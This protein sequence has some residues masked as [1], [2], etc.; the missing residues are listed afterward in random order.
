MHQKLVRLFLDFIVLV[1]MIFL[2]LEGTVDT[3]LIQQIDDVF[4]ILLMIEQILKI[5]AIHPRRFAKNQVQIFEASI[6]LIN[7][8]NINFHN[9]ILVAFKSLLFFR[10]LKYNQLAVLITAIA[11]KT[12]QQYI[13]LTFLMFF[14]IFVYGLIG[15]ELFAGNFD[16]NTELG[17]LHSYDDPIKAWITVFNILTNDDWY[18]V[19]ILGSSV[20]RFGTIFYCFS[21]IYIVN[22][23]TFGL[24]M[25]IL[26]DGFSQYL[27]EEG[28]D[29]EFL[30][31]KMKAIEKLQRQS[32]SDS[33]V[34]SSSTSSS[35]SSDE[36]QQV[37]EIIRNRSLIA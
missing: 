35:S 20:S 2:S 25:A 26:L 34:H 22:Y 12:F 36:E 37:K 10:C 9:R 27:E 17:Q 1:N 5:F 11:K 16:Q 30:I 31:Q 19:L 33:V 6:I 8:I 3:Q 23:L 18:G 28:E 24:V 21:M 15:M 4:T 7:F 29:D 32:D 13:Y 14:V